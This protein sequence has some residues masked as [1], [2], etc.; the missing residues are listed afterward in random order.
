[1]WERGSN[2]AADNVCPFLLLSHP[3]V[4]NSLHCPFLSLFLIATYFSI[5]SLPQRWGWKTHISQL[6][7]SPLASFFLLFKLCCRH[8]TVLS[9]LIVSS[10]HLLDSC[11]FEVRGRGWGW[12]GWRR[13]SSERRGWS[14][15]DSSLDVHIYGQFRVNNKT[16]AECFW[17]VGRK[18]KIFRVKP[19]HTHTETGW[20][21]NQDR[22]SNHQT[23][24]PLPLW[25]IFPH[26]LFYN[27]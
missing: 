25:P 15:L 13:S 1:M 22:E 16:N 5:T 4:P 27:T 19:T 2:S 6:S 3:V 26:C 11:S 23:S 9:F 24:D 17:T 14:S 20:T 7:N 12:G 18:P 8:L 10:F 21:C